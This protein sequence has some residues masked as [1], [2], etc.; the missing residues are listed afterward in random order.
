MQLGSITRAGV[1]ALTATAA[2]L[3]GTIVPGSA[4]ASSPST[5]R[6]GD[7][8]SAAEK[9]LDAEAGFPSGK[10]VQLLKQPDGTIHARREAPVLCRGITRHIGDGVAFIV[11]DS[12]EIA[13]DAAELIEIDWDGLDAHVDLATALDEGSPLL[14]PRAA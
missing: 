12:R 2:A 6:S 8:L 13:E 4:S 10:V 7:R 3:A 1:V 5:S 14:A 9:K 11:A